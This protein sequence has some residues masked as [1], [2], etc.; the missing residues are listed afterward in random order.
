MQND[1]KTIEVLSR[2]RLPAAAMGLGAAFML[3]GAAAPA[4]ADEV[5]M[6]H[7]IGDGYQSVHVI[8]HYEINTSKRTFD[9]TAAEPADSSLTRATKVEL[10]GETVHE[11][12]SGGRVGGG[13][14]VRIFLP[15]E[16]SPAASCRAGGR[17]RHAR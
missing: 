9:L 7:N 1:Q 8:T 16:T 2:K 17:Q 10:V 15:G 11:I 12:C 6:L 14:T 3:F 13:W 5:Q 4:S